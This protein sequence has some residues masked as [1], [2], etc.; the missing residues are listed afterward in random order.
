MEEK[1]QRAS[2]ARETLPRTQQA[3]EPEAA[4]SAAPVPGPSHCLSSSYTRPHDI[5]QWWLQEME[6][7]GQGCC[8]VWAW[9][10][11]S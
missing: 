11:R 2:H 1:L 6:E 4:A 7:P 5:S 3:L 8:V 9:I 10:Q